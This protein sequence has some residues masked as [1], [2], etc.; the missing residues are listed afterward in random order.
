M[1]GEVSSMSHP[2]RHTA[3]LDRSAT[4]WQKW[5]SRINLELDE[6]Y[7]S[8]LVWR[9]KSQ[10]NIVCSISVLSCLVCTQTG[11]ELKR[12]APRILFFSLSWLNYTNHKYKNA[13]KLCPGCVRSC[14]SF[15]LSCCTMWPGP[16]TVNGTN[17]SYFASKPQRRV[18]YK[19][20]SCFIFTDG[21]M[22]SVAMQLQFLHWDTWTVFHQS[23]I[24]LWTG[25]SLKISKTC[26][27]HLLWL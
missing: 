25:K 11:A 23:G 9:N 19:L 2:S 12:T 22:T 17:S 24:C 8:F 27:P 10:F 5:R 6:A 16:V 7:L 4:F 20:L 21:H 1:S 18:L 14:L 26:L 13:Q 15:L 3:C